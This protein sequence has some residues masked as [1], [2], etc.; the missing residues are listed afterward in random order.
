MTVLMTVPM[1]VQYSNKIKY[2]VDIID[3]ELSGVT[4]CHILFID[5]YIFLDEVV[6]L[7]QDITRILMFLYSIIYMYIVIL[8]IDNS[9]YHNYYGIN[10]SVCCD[11]EY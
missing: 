1:T 10:N 9:E 4:M 8:H 3:S 11:I 7:L 2:T 5:K 6:R